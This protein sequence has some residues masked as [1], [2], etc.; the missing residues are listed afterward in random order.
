MIEERRVV[1]RT[2]HVMMV[3]LVDEDVNRR[4]Q[5]SQEFLDALATGQRSR[6]VVRVEDV[7]ESDRSICAGEHRVQIVRVALA[8]RNGCDLGTCQFGEFVDQLAG[9]DR[10][11]YLP[12]WSGP[13][14]NR[15]AQDFPGTAPDD[16]PIWTDAVQIRN[17][18]A[19]R[20][21][22]DTR[23]AV[24]PCAPPLRRRRR[25]P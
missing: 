19:Q 5:T 16:D 3:R 2:G 1:A 12:S 21:C 6:G 14:L 24:G 4:R 10:G 23:V 9:R 25:R 22:G 11:E 20:F 13:R 15:Q 17:A 7:N 8:E 18:G